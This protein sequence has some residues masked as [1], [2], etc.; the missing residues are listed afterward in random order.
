MW[1]SAVEALK[2]LGSKPQTLYANVS[3]GRIRARPDPDDARRSLYSADDIE[4]LAARARGRRAAAEVA[5]EAVRWGEPVLNTAISTVID[6]RLIYRGLDAASLAL[7]DTYEAVAGLLLRSSGA[8]I[9]EALAS[10]G[11]DG[12]GVEDASFVPL[13]VELAERAERGETPIGLAAM[14][15]EAVTLLGRVALRLAPKGDE[16]GALHER[17]AAGWNAPAAAEPIRRALVVL[18]DHELNPSS[19]AARVT[20]STGAPLAAGLMTALATLSG[21][22]HGRASLEVSALVADIGE[23]R[24]VA[25]ALRLWLGEGRGVPGFGHRLYP[26]GDIRARVLLDGFD[27]P[28]AYGAVRKAAL[29][30]CGE[31][32][33]IDFALAALASRY[34]LPAMAPLMLFA[35]SRSAGWLAQMIEQVETAQVIRPRARYVPPN[36]G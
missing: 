2:R 12:Q 24:D 10:A 21:P 32:P 26:H 35:L 25:G 7:T 23:E 20:V 6:G 16:R 33:N 5:A 36:S 3:R 19:F 8:E 30:I 29:D 22:R 9:T 31:H 18:A 13:L 1:V 17:L 15:R 14:R 34:A 11:M 28:E 4:K 27:A